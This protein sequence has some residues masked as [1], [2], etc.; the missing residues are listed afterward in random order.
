MAHYRLG[1]AKKARRCLVKAARWIDQANREELDDPT[2][3]R[4][5]WGSWHETVVYPLLLREAE[6]LLAA[7]AKKN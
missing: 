6:A 1:H 3:L 7:K 5:G 2:S 4:P